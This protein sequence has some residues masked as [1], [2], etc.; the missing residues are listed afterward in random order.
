MNP[1]NGTAGRALL[2]PRTGLEIYSPVFYF[3]YMRIHS[4]LCGGLFIVECARFSFL[5]GGLVILRH[6]AEAVFPWQMY[7]AANALFV[8]MALFLWL[9]ASKYSVYV[10]LH[11]S[12]KSLSLF[13]EIAGGIAFLGQISFFEPGIGN[14]LRILA[15]LVIIDM[16]SLV[17]ALFVCIKNKKHKPILSG[18]NINVPA[19]GDETGEY[20]GV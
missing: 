1:S 10:P 19:Q 11:I 14:S 9:D 13:C 15:V 3:D 12:G 7:A 17:L 4:P 5:T 8:L 16:I 2:P 18:P 6:N 20:G